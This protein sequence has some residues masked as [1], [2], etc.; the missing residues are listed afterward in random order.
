MFLGNPN[1]KLFEDFSNAYMF[2]FNHKYPNVA[3]SDDFEYANWFIGGWRADSKGAGQ[4]DVTITADFGYHSQRSLEITAQ[5]AITVSEWQ[6]ATYI[7]RKIFVLNDSDVSLSF[8]I[9]AT[10]GF[11]GGE[12]FGPIV[13][14]LY[15][16]QTRVFARVSGVY[17]NYR[18]SKSLPES[19]GLFE[20]NGNSRLSTLASSLRFITARSFVL[21]LVNWDFDGTQNVAYLDNVAV[22]TAP[23]R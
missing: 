9:D 23:T 15:A 11:S 22:T 2:Q 1:F 7:S 4:R 20:F 17:E 16:N 13:S 18:Y 21:E 10:R 5:A 8:Y 19:E 3:F 6:Y 12:T 14:N